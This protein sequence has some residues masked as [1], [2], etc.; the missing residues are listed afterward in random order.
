MDNNSSLDNQHNTTRKFAKRWFGPY[1]VKKVENNATPFLAGL[2]GT[3]H[4][5][6]IVGKTIKIFKRRDTT[7]IEIEPLDDVALSIEVEEE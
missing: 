5:L 7:N 4:A 3:R 6:P 2:D 1:V